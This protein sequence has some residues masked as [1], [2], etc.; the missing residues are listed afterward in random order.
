MGILAWFDAHPGL[1]GWVQGMGSLI[2]LVVA[3]WVPRNIARKA[4]KLQAEESTRK[5]MATGLAV[6]YELRRIK[7]PLQ[8]ILEQWGAGH[9]MPEL[10][11]SEDGRRTEIG[12]FFNVPVML[13]QMSGRLHEL[14]EASHDAI[15]AVARAEE[16]KLVLNTIEIDEHVFGQADSKRL[17]QRARTLMMR[18][19]KHTND[20]LAKIGLILDESRT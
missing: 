12:E 17:E 15:L 11:G 10:I 16:I 20:A 8:V 9:E 18:C 14:G 6:R 7:H 3:I 19:L 5:A 4:A 13:T 2:A 1:A